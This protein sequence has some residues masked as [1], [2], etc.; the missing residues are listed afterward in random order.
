MFVDGCFWHACPVHGTMPK[1][2]SEWWREKLTR[3]VSRDREKDEGLALLGWLPVHV[4]EHEDPDEAAARVEALWAA[5]G[6]C[7]RGAAH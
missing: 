3:N 1:N 4:W 5:R 7:R 6:G 2:N